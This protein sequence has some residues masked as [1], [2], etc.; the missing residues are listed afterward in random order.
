MMNRSTHIGSEQVC[1]I[2]AYYRNFWFALESTWD[3][4]LHDYIMHL[5]VNYNDSKYNFMFYKYLH[6]SYLITHI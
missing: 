1:Y 2:A 6:F 5:F 3:Y 4:I